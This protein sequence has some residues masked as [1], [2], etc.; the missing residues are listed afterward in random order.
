M[1]KY[2]CYIPH[3]ILL[4]KKANENISTLITC[5]ILTGNC[6]HLWLTY[7][8]VKRHL[9]L[10]THRLWLCFFIYS[11]LVDRVRIKLHNF[12]HSFFFSLSLS[13][14]L[15][16]SR[17]LTCSMSLSHIPNN[18]FENLCHSFNCL[19][20]PNRTLAIVGPR[21]SPFHF[22]KFPQLCTLKHSK[23]ENR[24]VDPWSSARHKSNITPDSMSQNTWKCNPLCVWLAWNI[25]ILRM[26]RIAMDSADFEW[27][28]WKQHKTSA[29][30]YS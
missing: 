6:Q 1:C 22:L 16:L 4:C 20:F 28:S 21:L 30:S 27:K 8:P 23:Q 25:A 13:L 29:L 11:S 15:S 26:A 24:I 9:L 10:G 19:L 17:S 3:T 2:I 7:P 14:S 18:T 12:L 5:Y